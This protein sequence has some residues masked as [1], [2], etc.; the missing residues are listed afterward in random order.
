[1]NQN[2]PPHFLALS[3]ALLAGGVSILG[4]ALFEAYGAYTDL[5]SNKFVAELMQQITDKPLVLNPNTPFVL[6]EGG[7]RIAAV[8]LFF[9]IASVAV[10]AG[11]GLIKAGVHVL[12]PRF[13][14]QLTEL[15]ERVDRIVSQGKW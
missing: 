2:H 6:G 3:Y 8:F 14:H 5:A 10:A 9:M 12:S 1:M 13:E 11:L 4:F 15:K 7:A